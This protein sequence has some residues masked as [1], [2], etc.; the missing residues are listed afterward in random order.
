MNGIKTVKI[1]TGIKRIEPGND[2]LVS[3]Q[4]R[5]MLKDHR[6]T[7]IDRLLVD[8]KTYISYQFANPVTREQLNRI[9]E[10]L[11]LLKASAIDISRYREIIEEVLNKEVTYVKSELFYQEINTTISEELNPS[12]LML[13][14]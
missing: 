3:L 13:L 2:N 4:V 11:F 5:D 8:L 14:K 1:A 6:E 12:Q 9:V 7:L 10:K